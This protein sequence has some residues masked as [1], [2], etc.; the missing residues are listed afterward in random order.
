MDASRHSPDGVRLNA[1]AFGLDVR[2][3]NWMKRGCGF[4]HPIST[5]P[6]VKGTTLSGLKGSWYMAILRFGA[7]ITKQR[8]WKRVEP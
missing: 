1:E 3:A 2:R 6:N 4:S 7:S 5:A 8:T